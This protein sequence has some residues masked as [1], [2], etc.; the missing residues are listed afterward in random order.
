[1]VLAGDA[2]AALRFLE[3][4]PEL[5]LHDAVHAADLLLLAELQTVLRRAPRSLLPVL[6]RREVLGR[7]P[8][9]DRALGAEAALTLQ[10][11]LH[12]L[13]AADPAHGTGV[14]CHSSSSAQKAV[15]GL[16]LDAPPLRR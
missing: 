2:A 14:P 16:G 15:L 10:E 11:E 7:L 4:A 8:L 12:A 13:A 9:H 1:Q 5:P 6:P 3:V